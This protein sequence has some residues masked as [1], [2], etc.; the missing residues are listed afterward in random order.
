MRGVEE[1]A[2]SITLAALLSKLE[3]HFSDEVG[4]PS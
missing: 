4:R 1:L 2:A 3:R